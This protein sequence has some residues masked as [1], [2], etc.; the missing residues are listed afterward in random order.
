MKNIKKFNFFFLLSFF[1]TSCGQQT[2]PP[3]M[4]NDINE[5]SKTD[6]GA[7]DRLAMDQNDSEMNFEDSGPSLDLSIPQPNAVRE[8]PISNP[9][10]KGVK[11]DRYAGKFLRIALVTA[12]DVIGVAK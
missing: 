11:P 10:N 3:V 12:D 5:I 8:A 1:I 6:E 9:L 2:A 4:Q 7:N